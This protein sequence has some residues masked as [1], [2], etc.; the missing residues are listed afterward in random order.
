MIFFLTLWYVDF[1]CIA[2]WYLQIQLF[3][4][5]GV[6]VTRGYMALWFT[7]QTNCDIRGGGS[8]SKTP[9]PLRSRSGLVKWKQDSKLCWFYTQLRVLWHVCGTVLH[10]SVRQRLSNTSLVSL[11]LGWKKKKQSQPRP[12][13]RQI[14]QDIWDSCCIPPWL[15]LDG[16]IKN[17]KQTY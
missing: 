14:H 10:R 4:V 17:T 16:T 12:G 5:H 13:A 9:K 8:I 15:D 2:L 11:S 3:H 1:D 6:W 7:A